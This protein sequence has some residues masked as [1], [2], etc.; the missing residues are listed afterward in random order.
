[1]G[2]MRGYYVLVWLIGGCFVVIP[3]YYVVVR[4]FCGQYVAVSD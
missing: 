2:R 1:M 4:G 3:G